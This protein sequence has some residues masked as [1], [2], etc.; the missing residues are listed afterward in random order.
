MRIGAAQDMMVAGFDAIAIMQT[1]DWRSPSVVLRYVEHASTIELHVKRWQKL[2]KNSPA[3][4]F[5][6]DHD[7]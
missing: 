6:P 2:S 5:T 1:G 4:F 7:K 3:G